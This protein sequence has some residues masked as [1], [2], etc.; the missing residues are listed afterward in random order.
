MA[1]ASAFMAPRG[2]GRVLDLPPDAG[3]LIRRVL[4]G[5]GIMNGILAALFL[6]LLLVSRRADR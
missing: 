3:T 4:T 1:T 6:V 5:F 2:S